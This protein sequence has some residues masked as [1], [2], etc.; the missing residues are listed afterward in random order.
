MSLIWNDS[1][2]R[3][4][5]FEKN[6]QA[7]LTLLRI[8]AFLKQVEKFG[9]FLRNARNETTNRFYVA[10]YISRTSSGSARAKTW[11]AASSLT[12]RLWPFL[13]PT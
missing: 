10:V 8:F 13:V 9:T 6:V 5:L 1:V 12:R 2:G 11:R 7:L 4:S 3:S